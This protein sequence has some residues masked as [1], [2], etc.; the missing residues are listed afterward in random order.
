[1]IGYLSGTVKF[2]NPDSLIVEVGGIGY[3]V[4]VP[5]FIWQNHQIGQAEE[6][7]IYTHIKEDAFS[8][9][10]FINPADKQMF[11]NL[12]AI[13]G[14]GPK[15]ALTIISHAH[16]ANKIIRAI[17]EADVDYFTAIKGLGKKGAQRLIVDLKP[18]LGSLK[19]LEFETEQDLDLLEALKGLG[20]SS[21]E[22]KKAI[23]GIKK[24][25]PLEEKIRLALKRQ[26]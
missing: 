13:S 25:L 15:I 5:L 6:F 7:L 21:P 12:I 23:K 9:Y 14:I 26:S 11:V 4:F 16:G 3:Q 2:K 24:D 18:K 8:L 19:E 20:F 10:G 17:Q 22:I 1:M